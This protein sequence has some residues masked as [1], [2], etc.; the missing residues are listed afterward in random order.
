MH[1][2]LHHDYIISLVTHWSVITIVGAIQTVSLLLPW[3]VEKPHPLKM[4]H[5]Y[6][7]NIVLIALK[8]YVDTPT[9]LMHDIV[10]FAIY[11]HEANTMC[12]AHT[13]KAVT[14][15]C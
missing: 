12:L 4:A 8:R 13:F 6:H 9:S 2:A 15:E 11:I 14:M 7:I 3:I 5:P 1:S 10:W